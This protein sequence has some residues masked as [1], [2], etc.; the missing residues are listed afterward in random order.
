MAKKSEGYIALEN[1]VGELEK[2]LKW[3]GTEKMKAVEEATETYKKQLTAYVELIN[4]ISVVT[5][6][7]PWIN[8]RIIAVEDSTSK[9]LNEEKKTVEVK[10]E[11]IPLSMYIPAGNGN[12]TVMKY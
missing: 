1:R 8:D 7:P 2:D 10:E 3:A 5:E 11:D 12:I 9:L 4:V 6:L